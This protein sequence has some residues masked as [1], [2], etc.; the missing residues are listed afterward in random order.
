MK[1]MLLSLKQKLYNDLSTAVSSLSVSV[2]QNDQ[3]INTLEARVSDLYMA[4]NE[5]VDVVTDHQDELQLI[6]L[7]IADLEDR[8]RRNNIKFLN[9]PELIKPSELTKFLQSV[10]RTLIPEVTN[11][12]LEID[13]A[14]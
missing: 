4:H 14:H 12:D 2:Q 11:W 13:R 1:N 7:K 9:I 5:L 10:M 8:S 6:Q 3:R